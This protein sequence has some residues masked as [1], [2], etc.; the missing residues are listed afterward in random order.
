M[1]LPEKAIL[2][3]EGVIAKDW[4]IEY[5]TQPENQRIANLYDFFTHKL[6]KLRP[7]NGVFIN[8][9]KTRFFMY[10][11][12]IQ[13]GAGHESYK[14][15]QNELMTE[16]S[17]KQNTPKQSGT[18][19][20][21]RK[22]VDYKYS[23]NGDDVMFCVG[24]EMTFDL[25]YSLHESIAEVIKTNLFSLRLRETGDHY[26]LFQLRRFDMDAIPGK[27][28]EKSADGGFN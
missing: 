3:P 14:R 17:K 20:F 26:T 11:A 1:S 19:V 13:L 12:L 25:Y 21:N 23:L 5:H 2:S 16:L 4:A 28:A 6:G 18:F 9:I 22:G 8:A 10:V 7:S 15:I 24:S 27:H